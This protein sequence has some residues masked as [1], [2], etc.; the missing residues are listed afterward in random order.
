MFNDLDAT[1]HAPLENLIVRSNYEHNKKVDIL[2]HN[3]WPIDW[4]TLHNCDQKCSVIFLL[5]WE[6]TIIPDEWVVH[7]LS[8][9]SHLLAPSTF[10]LNSF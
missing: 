4:S 9:V 3:K 6:F 8:S 10:A 5:A 1:H 7:I 2:P